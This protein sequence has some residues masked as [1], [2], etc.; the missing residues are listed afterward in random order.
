MARLIY[1]EPAFADL[2]RLTDLLIAHDPPAEARTAELIIEAVEILANHPM[3]GRLVDSELR[4]LVISRGDSGY[5]AFYSYDVVQDVVII[6]A[7]RHQRELGY[8]GGRG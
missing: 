1:A 5:L 8:L 3:V 2:Q 4:E 7:I 6:L